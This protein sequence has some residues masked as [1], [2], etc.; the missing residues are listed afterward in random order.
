M[1]WQSTQILEKMFLHFSISGVMAKIILENSRRNFT[2]WPYT[3]Q[4]TDEVTAE[5]LLPATTAVEYSLDNWAGGSF[6]RVVF[7]ADTYKS[8]QN[9]ILD[10]HIWHF[11]RS[12]FWSIRTIGKYPIRDAK[13]DLGYT[14]GQDRHNRWLWSEN[15]C[16]HT[17]SD[18]EMVTDNEDV[19]LLMHI[20]YI[21]LILYYW[22]TMDGELT[23]FIPRVDGSKITIRMA[24]GETH[25]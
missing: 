16:C 15:T 3:S 4:F 2:R 19:E 25:V 23:K 13:Q 21:T 20:L 5:C 6:L 18:P 1:S 11:V 22:N 8:M 9:T 24:I 10:A 12:I 14:Y 7:E 17:M